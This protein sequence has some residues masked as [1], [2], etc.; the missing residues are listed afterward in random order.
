MTREQIIRRVG[1]IYRNLHD[2][3]GE[4]IRNALSDLLDCFDQEMICAE[5][6]DELTDY[7]FFHHENKKAIPPS[8]K[9]FCRLCL[10]S[11]FDVKI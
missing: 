7:E 2:S 4:D 9:K 5:C 3:E 11:C 8:T 6:G 10:E 1:E